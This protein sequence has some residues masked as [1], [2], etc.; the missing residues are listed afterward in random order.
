MTNKGWQ[1][2]FKDD[3]ASISHKEAKLQLLANWV[4]NAY[5][6]N[7]KINY[8][9]LEPV[10]YKV[11]P[12]I[13][14]TSTTSNIDLYHKRL[15]HINKDYILKTIDNTLGLKEVNSDSLL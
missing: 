13:N 12:V 15:L 6:I 1:I 11:D 14:N 8:S 9:Q 7:I 2:L 3:N 10:V 5:Y 4:S